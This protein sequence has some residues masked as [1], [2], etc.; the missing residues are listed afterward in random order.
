MTKYFMIV[1]DEER[2]EY[3]ELAEQGM[4]GPMAMG[5]R[6]DEVSDAQLRS[7]LLFPSHRV[8]QLSRCG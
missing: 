6:E 1:T 7:R 2:A 5:P 3:R 8:Q 4:M